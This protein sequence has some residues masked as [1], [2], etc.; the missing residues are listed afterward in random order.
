MTRILSYEWVRLRSLRSTWMLVGIGI[1]VSA[2]IACAYSGVVWMITDS[3]VSVPEQ[4]RLTVTV[5]K[6]SAAPVIGG[7]IAL[8]AVSGDRRHQTLSTT[9]LIEPHRSRT[10][11]AKALM[12]IGLSLVLALVTILINLGISTLLLGRPTNLIPTDWVAALSVG[13]FLAA[14]VGWCVVG[15][16]LGLLIR[17]HVVALVTLLALPFGVERGLGGLAASTDSA[18]LSRLGEFLPF[19]SAA[20]LQAGPSIDHPVIVVAQTDYG[21]SF[22]TFALFAVVLLVIAVK[23][24]AT[25][26]VQAG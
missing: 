15:L 24:F 21:T 18:R 12:A 22:V 2:L 25:E 17:N 1:A 26:D 10:V 4:E 5:T 13:G 7:V 6:A 16:S 8:L 19:R 23:V 9:L 3:G 14:T 20:N 11:L